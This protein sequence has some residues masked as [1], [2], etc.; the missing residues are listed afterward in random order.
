MLLGGTSITGVSPNLFKKYF[1]E[2][3]LTQIM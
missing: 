3:N 1:S 2:I